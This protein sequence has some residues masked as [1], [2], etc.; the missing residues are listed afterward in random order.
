MATKTKQMD[1]IHVQAFKSFFKSTEGSPEE[2]LAT[3]IVKSSD[4]AFESARQSN[5]LGLARML[6]QWRKTNRQ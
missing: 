1:L 6:K 5:R 3:A 2:R 4:E